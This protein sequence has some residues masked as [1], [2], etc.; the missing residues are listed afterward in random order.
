MLCLLIGGNTRIQFKKWVSSTPSILDAGTSSIP[1]RW[2]PYPVPMGRYPHPILMWGIPYQPARWVPPSGRM[3]VL[4]LHK[5]GCGY[6]PLTKDEVPPIRKDGGVPH[7]LDRVTPPPSA[8]WGYPP[9]RRCE[10]TENITFLYPSDAGGNEV[11]GTQA[12]H[13][14]LHSLT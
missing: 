1:D 14:L 4:L 8:R 13:T 12:V 11:V 3:V 10:Q 5:E 6:P 7:E 9:S 2:Y